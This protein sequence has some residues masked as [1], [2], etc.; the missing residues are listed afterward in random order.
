MECPNCKIEMKFIHQNIFINNAIT[1]S[2]DGFLIHD[3]Q[4]NIHSNIY[5]CPKCG[6]VE[7]YAT[8]DCLDNLSDLE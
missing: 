8:K 4:S 1:H 5:V 3:R 2:G 6:F 7:Q